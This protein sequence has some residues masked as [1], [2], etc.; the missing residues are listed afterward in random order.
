MDPLSVELD[1]YLVITS[2]D[3]ERL[4][5]IDCECLVEIQMPMLMSKLIM[6]GYKQKL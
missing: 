5:Q 2:A 4:E 3:S 6:L 1:Q